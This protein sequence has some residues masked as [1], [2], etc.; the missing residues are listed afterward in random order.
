MVNIQKSS[1]HLKNYIGVGVGAGVGAGVVAGVEFTL[2][3]S[4]NS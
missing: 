1:M 3:P 4:Q 2:Q